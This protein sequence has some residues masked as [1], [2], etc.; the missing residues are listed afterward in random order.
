MI[1]IFL[2]IFFASRIIIGDRITIK[3]LKRVLGAI[4]FSMIFDFSWIIAV[5]GNYLSDSRSRDQG[6]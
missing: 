3:G 1:D 4:I 2:G 6:A 5:G